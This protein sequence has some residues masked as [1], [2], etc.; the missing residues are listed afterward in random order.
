[1]KM[2]YDVFN[3]DADGICALHQLRL[4]EPHGAELVT[5]VK[6]D[7][8]LLKK[9]SGVKDAH[10][11]VLD[12]SMD[13]NRGELVELLKT[14]TVFYVDHHFAGEIP[15]AASLTAHID[16]SPEV[17]TSLIVDR[18]LAG[19][20][21]AWAIMAAF[22]DNIHDSANRAARQLGLPEQQTALLREAGELINY[23]GYG[24]TVDD[25][26]LH[27]R[28][29]YRAISGFEDPFDFFRNSSILADLREGYGDDMARARKTEPSLQWEHGRIFNF[30]GE[31]WARRVAGVFSN[32]KSR[33]MPACAHALVV[34]NNDG[35]YMISVRAPLATRK[36]ADTLCRSF[37]TGGGRA[38]AAGINALPA[39][40][41]KQFHQSFQEVFGPWENQQADRLLK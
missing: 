27:P 8:N 11:T 2:F 18:L 22:G 40:L 37:P 34:D 5:G 21:R 36:G 6:R 39:A 1:M 26:H 33:E 19:R 35:T 10:L 17:C 31:P 41:L 15:A 3:G 16:P 9:V 24:K 38:G 4:A 20:Y 12:I 32:E 28:E 29:L 14:C 13:S 25:L 30:P 23:N 7:I